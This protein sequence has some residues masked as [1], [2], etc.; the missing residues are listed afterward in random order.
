MSSPILFLRIAVPVPL[1]RLFD[2]Q[3]NDQRVEIGARV[4]V[5]FGNRKLVG[6]VVNTCEKHELDIDSSKLKSVDEVLDANAIPEDLINIANWI[7]SYYLVPIGMVYELILPV[8]LRKGEPL[9]PNGDSF[10]Q[11]KNHIVD[12]ENQQFGNA[13]AQR[14]LFEYL[15]KNQGSDTQTLHSNFSNWR[16]AMKS[17]VEKNIVQKTER[18][19]FSEYAAFPEKNPLT[20]SANQKEIVD[21]IHA[22]KFATHLIHG[23]TGSGKTEVYLSIVEQILNA[24]L[25]SHNSQAYAPQALLL[26]PEISLTPQFVE[27]I[28]KRLNKSVAVIHSGLNDTERHKAWWAASEGK[29]DIVLG[30]RASVFT[31][32][33][34]LVIIVVDEE[35]DAS[36]KQQDGVRYH[37]RD[38]AIVR[39]KQNGIPIIMGSATPSFESLHNVETGKFKL[40]TL[41]ARATGTTLPS[42]KLIDTSDPQQRPIDGLSP[43]LIQQI[44]QRL[45]VKQ[46]SI[47]FINRRGFSPTLY[48]TE[49]AWIAECPRCDAR[50]TA[51]SNPNSGMIESIRCHHCGYQSRGG[52]Q[53]IQVC[54][55]CNQQTVMPMG[56]GTQRIEE[57]LMKHF[58]TAKVS[59]LDRDV[60]TQKKELEKQLARIQSNEVDIILGTQM[61]AKG[62]DFPNVTLVGVIDADQG[63]FAIDFRG[64]EKL[65]QQLLQVSGRAGR[66][67]VGEV[68]IQTQFPDHPFFKQL[69]NQ[70]YVGFARAEIE[71]RKLLSY[72]PAG[73]MALLRAE[74]T[75]ENQGLDFLLW[76]RQQVEPM[77]NVFVSDAVSAPMAK[78]AGRYRAQLLMQSS[79]RQ[80]LQT[81][82]RQLIARIADSKQQSKVR[83]SIDVDPIDL[84]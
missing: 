39:A 77:N 80:S 33:K 18:L 2:Y 37:A 11:L 32:F 43:A 75:Y 79:S 12:I 25:P 74:S 54:G 27:R 36:F 50:L 7:A 8:R 3:I 24:G 5:S 13:H 62:H 16:S 76:C 69:L 22:N 19:T 6:V 81:F 9:K 51:H 78:R 71:S 53:S 83:W 26:V 31:P 46:Q 82:Q 64:T 52:N 29:V 20:L 30:T 42:M 1:Y 65:Y 35:H 59:R 61:L 56:V 23:V 45:T 28:R 63:L 41:L 66:H 70:D 48:C 55:S 60:I 10:W 40:S 17:L 44:K 38:V 4:K 72:P 58:P 84:Y 15:V 67:Q 21:S 68:Y 49:C 14:R 47:L 57:A 73:H 34:N